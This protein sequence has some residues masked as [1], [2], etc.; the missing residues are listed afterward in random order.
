[1]NTQ[2]VTE[3]RDALEEAK[4][5]VAAFA[6]E[7]F[8]TIVHIIDDMCRTEIEEESFLWIG[9]YRRNMVFDE[10]VAIDI[11]LSA[12]LYREKAVSFLKSEGSSFILSSSVMLLLGDRIFGCKPDEESNDPS[13]EQIQIERLRWKALD[14]FIASIDKNEIIAALPFGRN[15]CFS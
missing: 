1:M 13:S 10:L 6:N 9:G 3:N 15:I 12:R 7:I 8:S 4:R 2:I 14:S 5:R 11:S